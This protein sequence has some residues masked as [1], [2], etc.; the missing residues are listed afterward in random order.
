MPRV[1]RWLLREALAY[2]AMPSDLIP[3]FIRVLGHPADAVIVA[4]SEI[5]AL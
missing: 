4:G 5:L 2:A 1:V 3:L